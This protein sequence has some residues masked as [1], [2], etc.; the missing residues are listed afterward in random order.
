MTTVRPSF[1]RALSRRIVVAK[2]INA[3]GRCST[4]DFR[5]YQRSVELAGQSGSGGPG[6]QVLVSALRG[7]RSRDRRCDGRC[8]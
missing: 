5:V 4:H 8:R 6:I 1:C 3:L 2:D 7:M